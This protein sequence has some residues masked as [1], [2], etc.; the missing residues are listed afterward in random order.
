VFKRRVLNEKDSTCASFG[1]L[2]K[3]IN[4]IYGDPANAILPCADVYRN[5]ISRLNGATAAFEKELVSLIKSIL[6]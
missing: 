3:E 6:A 2:K 4:L 5:A 1:E